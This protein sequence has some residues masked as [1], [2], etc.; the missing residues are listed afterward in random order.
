MKKNNKHYRLKAACIAVALWSSCVFSQSSFVV[1]SIKVVGLKRVRVGTVYN[2]IPIQVGETLEPSDTPAIIRALY[3]TGFFKSVRLERSGQTL[4]IKVEERATIGSMTVVGNTEIPS[5][6]MKEILKQIGLV[7][8]R[9]YQRSALEHLEKELKQ[10]YIFR[11]KYSARIESK[12]TPLTEN[13]VAIRVDISEGR[14]A[15]IREIN[16]TGNQAFSNDELRGQM[17][18]HT[19]NLIT[20]FSKSDQYSKTSFETSLESIRS[21][22]LDQGYIKFQIVSSQVLLSPDKK[23]VYIDIHVKEGPQYHF[24]GYEVKGNTILP[25]EKVDALVLVKPKEVFSRKKVTETVTQIGNALGDV[26]YGFPIIRAEPTLDE[27]NKTVHMTFLVEPGRHVYVRRIQFKGN[28]KTADYVLR[29]VLRQ[30]EGGLLS[31]HNIKESERQLRVLGYLKDVQVT[32]TPV[33]GANNQVDLDVN[34][35]EA[36]SAEANASIGYGTNGPQ[37]NASFNQH[38]FMGTGRSMGVQF[39]A[40]YWGQNYSVNYFNPFYSKL[41]IGRGFNGYFETVDPRHLDISAYSSDRFGGDV[42]Y[43]MLLSEHSSVQFGYGYQGLDI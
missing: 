34:I 38:N 33:P 4:V 28:T 37:F 27:K 41:G 2:Y 11:G 6:K 7:K 36:P 32:T 8:G 10:V 5:D 26:G 3:D 21:F 22:Y 9:V 24:S 18:L 14:V 17:K 35:E 30:N 1:Q 31:L 40:S 13:R 16:F 20:Y 25:Q 29:D 39:N 23:N 12:I 19:S 15:R 42:N 43:S